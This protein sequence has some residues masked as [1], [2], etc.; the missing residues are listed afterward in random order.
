ML[1]KDEVQQPGDWCGPCNMSN[2]HPGNLCAHPQHFEPFLAQSKTSSRKLDAASVASHSGT[3]K[4]DADPVSVSTSPVHLCTK[5]N[6]SYEG[7]DLQNVYK[8]GVVIMIKKNDN[9]M[10]QFIWDTIRPTL[11]KAFAKQGARDYLRRRLASTLS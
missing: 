9:L 2:Q 11:L 1:D 10:Q 7:R 5:K 3:R 4:L 8:I 6:H